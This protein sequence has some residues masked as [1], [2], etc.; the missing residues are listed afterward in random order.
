MITQSELKYLLS[1]DP[2]TG[3]FIWLVSKPP[4]ISVGS[5]AGCVNK[6]G[7]YQITINRKQYLAHRLAWV[8][9]TG[10]WPPN[11]IDHINGVRNDN[12]I[13]NL[14]LATRSQNTT[15]QGA[16]SDNTTKLKGITKITWTNKDGTIKVK[17]VAKCGLNNIHHYIGSYP[18]AELA[19]AAYHAF[20]KLHHG[21]FYKEI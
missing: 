20:A 9:M 21:E 11:D 15:N 3:I 10:E 2:E 12:R 17:Y 18:T 4:R 6:I 8:Y 19:S 16:H 14:R 1:Y 7:Y 13:S 5:I